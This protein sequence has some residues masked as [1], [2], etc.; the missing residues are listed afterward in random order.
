MRLKDVE[1]RKAFLIKRYNKG[2]ALNVGCGGLHLDNAVNFDMNPIKK[3]D[4]IGD[5]H[6]LPFKDKSFDVVFALDIIE[7]TKT[8][9]VLLNELGR[10]GNNIIIECLD[11]DLCPENW[12]ADKTHFFYINQK[13]LRELLS[14]SGY[15]V[16]HFLRI[17]TNGK[18]F[19][20]SMLVGV[21]KQKLLDKQIYFL[22][23]FYHACRR[24]LER[25]LEN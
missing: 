7:H 16:F 13:I 2:K 3:P 20:K 19:R 5:F 9:D 6:Y 21:K 1:S 25:M 11:F 12:I 10:V 14:P 8:P 17:H 15:H 18:H 4:I 24:A 23:S 22:V